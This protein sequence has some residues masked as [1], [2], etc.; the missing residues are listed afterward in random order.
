MKN[1]ERFGSHIS[2]LYKYLYG[3]MRCVAFIYFQ[4]H[5]QM[6]MCIYARAHA[7]MQTLINSRYL[8]FVVYTLV[9]TIVFPTLYIRGFILFFFFLFHFH[10]FQSNW[11]SFMLIKAKIKANNIDSQLNWNKINGKK[12]AR[13]RFQPNAPIKSKLESI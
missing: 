9:Y 7:H 10:L 8:N 11:N 6:C 2:F 12:G 5:I 13:T 1:C 4:Q 3:Y